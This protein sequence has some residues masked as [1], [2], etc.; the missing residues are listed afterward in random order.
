VE[1]EGDEAE[2]REVEREGRAPALLEEDEEP[3]E[4]VDDADEVEVEVAR[5]E[6]PLR[7]QIFEVDP[8]EA[9]IRRVRRALDEIPDA[10]ADARH[11]QVV[12]NV[13]S[14]GDLVALLAVADDDPDEPVARH[15]AEDAFAPGG[16]IGLD[17]VGD[18]PLRRLDPVDAVGRR[19][20]VRQALREVDRAGRD[21]HRRHYQQRPALRRQH[22]ILHRLTR[23]TFRF[24]LRNASGRVFKPRRVS[25]PGKSKVLKQ[26]VFQLRRPT[27]PRISVAAAAARATRIPVPARPYLRGARRRAP[28]PHM[29]PPRGP[30]HIFVSPPKIRINR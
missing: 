29:A 27:P 11:L 1:D 28:R 14:G 26:A 4:Q 7:R 6:R 5:G 23:D 18:E 24:N 8:V 22:G 13:V 15:D 25:S 9:R 19:G 30:I 3:D 20:L 16:R 12:L 17:R 21:E 10:A 2:R